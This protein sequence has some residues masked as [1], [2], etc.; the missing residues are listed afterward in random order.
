M[1]LIRWGG[2]RLNEWVCL[3]KGEGGKKGRWG[4]EGMWMGMGMGMG[5]G[6]GKRGGGGDFSSVGLDWS[7]WGV[8]REEEVGGIHLRGTT[9]HRIWRGGED[10]QPS[11]LKE[12][13]A[14]L[15]CVRVQRSKSGTSH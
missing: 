5:M 15:Y 8:R 9:V 6:G 3:G 7:D 14:I 12:A 1:G 2:A 4:E 13:P 11:D 10:C